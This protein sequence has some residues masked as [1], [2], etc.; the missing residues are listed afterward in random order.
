MQVPVLRSI[1]FRLVLVSLLVQLV[2]L[3]ILV[4]NSS[5]VW[6]EVSLRATEVR[7]QELAR[8]LNSSL[9]PTMASLDYTSAEEVLES[10]RTPEGIDYL[11]LFDRHN[12]VVAVRGWDLGS[13]LPAVTQFQQLT[14]ERLPAV[15]HRQVTIELAGQTYGRLHFGVSTEQLRESV[16]RLLLQNSI[17]VAV[18]AL[19]SALIL[20]L[21]G[22]WLTRHLYRLIDNAEHSAQSSVPVL[23]TVHGDDEIGQ[24]TRRFNQMASNIQERVEA[25][26]MSEE[27]F[28]AI[29]DYTYGGEFWLNPEGRLVWLNHSVERL[30]G[31]NEHEC[32]DMVHFPLPIVGQEDRSNVA[33]QIK[34]AL[35]GTSGQDFEFRAVRRDGRS[36][37]ASLSWQPIYDAGGHYQGIRASL[38][39]NSE[40][41]EDRLALKKAV[42]ELRQTQTL[43][44]SYL[45]RAEQERARLSALLSAMRFGV[46]FVDNENLVVYHN[47]AFKTLWLI[48]NATPVMGKPMAQVLRQAINM[49]ADVDVL[50]IYLQLPEFS[51]DRAHIAELTLNDQR[52]VAQQCF[53]LRDEAGAA[54]GKLWVFEDVTQERQLNE[55]ML[56]LAE[57]DALTGLYNRHAFQLQLEQLILDAERNQEGVALLF[58]DLDEFKYVN[59]TFG[60]GVGDDLLRRIASEVS[61]QVRRH[62]FFCR[63]GGDEFA[64]LMP[65]ASMTDAKSLAERV[66]TGV[67][68][69]QFA[70][71]A[72]PLRLSSSLGI[73]L[74]PA[75]AESAEELVAH[76][77][78]AMYQAKA[79]GKNTWRLY[80]AN[81]DSSREMVNRLTWN[82]RIQQALDNDGFALFFQGIYHTQDLS[83]AHLEALVRMKDSASPGGII[84]PNQFIPHAERSGK[85][86]EIDRWV[87]REAVS[88]LAEHGQ[89]PS[90][91]VNISG[92]S[93]DEPSLPQFINDTLIEYGVAPVR[94]M[95]E[96]TETA[97]VSDM[98]DA[99]R[100]IEALRAT[101]CTVC[102]D[103]FGA[104]FSSFAY[105]KHLQA[106]VL[107][108]DGLFIRDLPNDHDSQVF[109]K[110]MTGMARD[111]GKHTVAE[112][113]ENEEI[114]NMLRDI[115]VD[116]VQGYHLDR[117]MT[118]EVALQRFVT[119]RQSV[120]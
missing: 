70:V 52:I 67:A 6:V 36:F 103:D 50:S 7:T 54:S 46:L 37:W 25:V 98:R 90:I 72:Q 47:P 104:G 78:T 60:H 17:L 61:N 95:V 34:L 112:F 30:T 66:V 81:K 74:Y 84:P 107:K 14:H 42:F 31:Y 114:L 113:V 20:G 56:F 40:L 9:A 27:R 18:G 86:I 116:M 82:E 22:Y 15:I 120:H 102:L 117:P 62:E 91:A 100:F 1:R 33:D 105:L 101:G 12:R 97:A 32:L 11:V 79:A 35:T 118:A 44:Q 51:D 28:H 10:V 111:M 99:Q 75:H 94:L 53:L 29:A 119:E 4:L 13:P 63:L 55:K 5:R 68:Q 93:F 43:G 49:P 96:V 26:R 87:I 23:L 108:I 89:L 41:K 64:I 57:R 48:D 83:V 59:D 106:Q 8:L 3:A 77:D 115:G 19:I 73:A 24:L 110:G 16:D 85:I 58:F 2:V 80:E 71:D 109:V 69:I 65:S 38:R 45:E 88:L 92:R 76:A 21:L 39:D